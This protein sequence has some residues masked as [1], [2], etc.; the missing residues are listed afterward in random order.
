MLDIYPENLLACFK[1]RGTARKKAL[2][3]IHIKYTYTILAFKN[4]IFIEIK[5]QT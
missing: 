4:L 1:D 5:E 2:L 3:V